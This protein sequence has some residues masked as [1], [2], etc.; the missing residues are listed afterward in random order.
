MELLYGSHMRERLEEDLKGEGP[1]DI[2]A[3]NVELEFFESLFGQYAN[4]NRICIL[5]DYRMKLIV[6][7]FLHSHDLAIA[8]HWPKNG[9]LHTKVMVFP[10]KHVVYLGSHNF[11]WFAWQ[12]AQNMT[13]RVESPKLAY[14]VKDRFDYLWC[15]SQIVH[16][17][18][19]GLDG[20]GLSQGG[21]QD[22]P[23]V[24]LGSDP[25]GDT[26]TTYRVTET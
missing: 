4:K 3:Y 23:R 8:K 12:A 15:K 5:C 13:L 6:G 18:E 11:T 7:R 1:L 17:V 14:Q 24:P 26:H 10:A 21:Q 25:E 19:P 16:P 22:A 2:F 9:M 20:H